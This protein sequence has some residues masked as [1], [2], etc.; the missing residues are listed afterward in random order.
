[1]KRAALALAFL[2]A[3]PA[4]ASAHQAGDFFMRAGPPKVQTMCWE[5]DRSTLTTIR[6][7]V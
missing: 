3:V 5:W 2:T 7:W 6:S 4:M 1:M